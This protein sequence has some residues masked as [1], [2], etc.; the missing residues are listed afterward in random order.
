MTAPFE[1]IYHWSV[2]S[3]EA[4]GNT[5]ARV[6]RITLP[7]KTD[8]GIDTQSQ[9]VLW[10]TFPGDGN[11]DH[12]RSSP[13]TEQPPIILEITYPHVWRP[14]AG[15]WDW[16][17]WGIKTDA[18]CAQ[19]RLISSAP[20][21]QPQD[22]PIAYLLWAF[23]LRKMRGREMVMSSMPIMW[24]L[25]FIPLN[26]WGTIKC[27]KADTY[28]GLILL[29]KQTLCPKPLRGG[30]GLFGLIGHSS[31]LREVYEGTQVLTCA[32]YLIPML[33]LFFTESHRDKPPL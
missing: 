4:L 29:L 30:K 19:P 25:H 7:W 27:N 13:R 11:P 1:A 16:R 12:F 9:I 3:G 31:P 8:Q 10:G 26:K 5:A 20:F 24:V 17:V 21:W 22:G 32:L 6:L 15:G 28:A 23:G 14:D 2:L 18:D 33:A